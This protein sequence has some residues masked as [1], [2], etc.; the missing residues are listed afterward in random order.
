M[1]AQ[2][3]LTRIHPSV[4]SAPKWAP[5]AGQRELQGGS[6]MTLPTSHVPVNMSCESCAT[7]TAMC[8]YLSVFHS[9]CCDVF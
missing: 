2:A 6:N 9:F 1:E 8:A 5:P 3:L 7:V 4:G